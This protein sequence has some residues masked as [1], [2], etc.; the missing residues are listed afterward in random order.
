MNDDRADLTEIVRLTGD[1]LD[2]LAEAGVERISLSA[3][4]VP[5]PSSGAAEAPTPPP[6]RRSRAADAVPKPVERN[7]TAPAAA[8]TDFPPCHPRPSASLRLNSNGGPAQKRS[9]P[10][11]RVRG[12]DTPQKK[13]PSAD[14]E[15]AGALKKIDRAVEKCAKCGLAKTRTRTVFGTGSTHPPVLFIGEAP[16]AEED[17]QGLPFVGR[18]GQLL[19][20]MLE[21][22]G[23]RREDVYITN[24][25][26]CRPPGNRDP[27]PGEVDCC[28]PYLL[29]QL[30][31]LKPRLICALGRHAAQTLLKTDIGINKLRGS[32]HDYHGIKIL[33][34]FHPAYLLRNPPDKRKSWEDLKKVR[35]FVDESAE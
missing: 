27:Q 15:I 7:T 20:K 5:D 2:R 32:F 11:S 9:T 13:S 35:A 31:L 24:V 16:G 17:R 10:D 12:N 3:G 25:L 33:P 22:I 4:N 23:F 29:E 26:K 30:A 19:T 14:E 6:E 21:A 1:L 8:E 18:A 34:T 28:E